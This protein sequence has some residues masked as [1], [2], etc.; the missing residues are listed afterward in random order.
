ML[1]NP[2]DFKHD[3]ESAPWWVCSTFED[4]DNI[5]W[6]WNCMYDE[7]ANNHIT[8]RKAKV[9]KHSLPWMNSEIRKEMNKRYKLLK[10]CDGTPST[11]NLWA[12]NKSSR[13]KVSKMLR[14]AEA[15]YWKKKFTETKDS[16]SFW[17]TVNEAT[18][19][20]KSKQ[21]SLL[22]D[23]D[24]KEITND[25]EKA[26]LINSYFINIG[27]E[28]AE[29]FPE[30]DEPHQFIY[31]VTPTVQDLEVNINKLI[32]DIKTIN[33]NKASGPDGI[34][35]RGLAI[36]G[37][38]ALEGIVT[39][40]KNSMT[41]SSF[42]NTWKIAK[43]N[44]IFKKGDPA[45]VSNYRPISLLSIPSKLLESQICSI[46]DAHLNSCG[47]KSCKQWGFSKGLS[48]EGMLTSMT[49]RWKTAIDNG[50]TV[51]AVFIDFQKAFDTVPHYILSHKL[52]A[53]G[54]SGSLHEWL[55]SYLTDRRQFT[56]VNNCRSAT[57]YVRYGVPQG[58]LLGPRLYTIYVNDLPDHIDSGDLYMY[59]DD[60]TVYCIGPNVDL[61]MS[62]LNKTMEQ[63]LRWSVRNQLTIH[64]IKTEAM[65]M[66]KTSFVGPIPPLYF[67]TGHIDLVNYTTCLGVKIDNKLTWSVHIDS[68]KKHFTQKVGALK[69]MRILPKKV[70]EEIYFKTIIPSV[71]YGISVWGNCSPSALNSLHHIHARAARI[72][73]NLNS[74]M[75]DETCLIKSDWLPISYFYKKSVLLFMHKVYYETTSQS[76]CELFS[77]RV[78]SR[79]SRVPNQ[80]NIIRFK[81][82]TGRNTL[83]YRG[84]V[85]WN[86]V[87]RLV[88]VPDNSYSFK[89]I[90]RKHVKIIDNFSFDK[91]ATV[92]AN[93]K[94][95]FIYF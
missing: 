91:G 41:R 89:Q 78:T 40:F 90:L 18:G 92:V 43:V 9:R 13:N 59:A 15:Q 83:Q 51:G 1:E 26:E 11:N 93:K 14:C 94:D 42:P 35:S 48:T 50:L 8:L 37:S 2:K 85:I 95:D 30:A 33:I 4:L 7:I 67:N 75:A 22:R 70:L 71:T 3:L 86:F 32:A 88:E 63:V 56:E 38:S 84:P 27:R 49:E 36:A 24:N 62:S 81:S 53:I 79:S 73:N 55:M 58:S 44:A 17:K 77:K 12:D 69:R 19:K 72:V 20:S 16:K 25:Y 74:T 64:P 66:R 54:I 82:E 76:I 6:A 5:T 65:I 46:I 47:T 10:A 61:V 28:L 52:H 39:V 68:V 80:F 21:I 29:K 60:T 57:D 45:D 87:N 34:S 31:R 23:T